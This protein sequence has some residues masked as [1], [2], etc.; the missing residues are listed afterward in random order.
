MMPQRKPDA[1]SVPCPACGREL[2][3][4]LSECPH[5][6]GMTPLRISLDPASLAKWLVRILVL[7]AVGFLAKLVLLG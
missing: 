1:G 7:V 5:C 3:R 4:G 6:G 2:D